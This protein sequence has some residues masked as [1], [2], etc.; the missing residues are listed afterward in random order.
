MINTKKIISAVLAFATIVSVSACSFAKRDPEEI[1]SA[2]D[3]FAKCVQYLDAGRLLDN[4]ETTDYSEADAFRKKLAIS[5]L[6]YDQASLKYKIADVV[7]DTAVIGRKDASCDVIFTRADYKSA[8]EGFVGFSSAY[9]EQLAVC[10]KTLSYTVTLN[11]KKVDGRWLA[12]SDSLGK[13][14]ELYAFL[15]EEFVFGPSTL[16]LIDTAN[17]MFTSDGNYKDTI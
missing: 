11:F 10:D 14:N 12:A 4:V 1:Y 7:K 2:A 5:E 3:T 13:L 9:I 15:D 6:D 8:F 17:W 16:D